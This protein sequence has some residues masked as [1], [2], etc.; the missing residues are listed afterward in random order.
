LRTLTSKGAEIRAFS[1]PSEEATVALKDVDVLI[2]TQGSSSL[3]LQD[4]ILR[5]AV[6]AGVKLF[7]PAEYGITTDGRSEPFFAHKVHLR[8]E[9]AR[10]GLPTTAFY[11]GIWTEFV[12]DVVTEYDREAGVLS[13]KGGG[14]GAFSVTGLDDVA[15]FIAYALTSLPRVQL[16]N[17]KFALETD[18]M[19]HSNPYQTL[20]H[21]DLDYVDCQPNWRLRPAMRQ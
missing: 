10:L 9:A 4:H 11:T 8:E 3:D 15:H 12:L 6:D 5:P 14:D 19:V 1:V 17:A 2:S 13:I 20:V 16:E 21:A 7:V 18:Q